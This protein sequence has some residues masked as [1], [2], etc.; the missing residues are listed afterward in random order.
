MPRRRWSVLGLAACIWIAVSPVPVV[1]AEGQVI[2]Q[3]SA[4]GMRNLR[5][6]TVKDRWEIQWES[7][8]TLLTITIY[9]P[10][11]TGGDIAAMQNGPGRGSSYL[12]KGGE[13]YLQVSGVGEWTVTVMQLP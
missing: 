4:N 5:P 7:K 8:G 6:F 2:Q 1:A 13:Y 11:G 12:P 9:K 10:D 3:V